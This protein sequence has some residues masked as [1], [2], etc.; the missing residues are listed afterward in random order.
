MKTPPPATSAERALTGLRLHVFVLCAL[1]VATPLT[2]LLRRSPEFLVTHGLTGMGT[3]ALI[4]VLLLGPPVPFW[5]LGGFGRL[6]GAGRPVISGLSIA[7][8]LSLILLQIGVR[9]GLGGWGAASAGLIGGCIGAGAYLRLPVVRTFTSALLLV[10][11]IAPLRLALSPEI[12]RLT[13]SSAAGVALE[14]TGAESSVVF[15]IFDELPMLSLTLQDGN[16]DRRNFPNFAL[17]AATSHVFIDVVSISTSTLTAV[18][19]I[20]RGELPRPGELPN[21]VDAPRNLFTLFGGDHSIRAFEPVT[22]LC[23]EPLNQGS[24]SRKRG[25]LGTLVS[26]LWIVL[27]HLSLPRPWADALPT[28][29]STWFDFAG[30]GVARVAPSAG[31]RHTR[32]RAQLETSASLRGAEFTRFV[33]GL[34]DAEGPALHFIHAALPHSPTLFAPDGRIYSSTANARHGGRKDDIWTLSNEPLVALAYQRHLLQL[35]YVDQLLG[36]L[37]ERLRSLGTFDDTTL[38]VTADHGASFRPGQAR[39]RLTETNRSEAVWVP[40]FIKAAGQHAA[41]VHEAPIQTIDIL[42]TLVELLGMGAVDWSFDGRSALDA[43]EGDREATDASAARAWKTRAFGSPPDFSPPLLLGRHTDLIGQKVL[44]LPVARDSGV[45][46]RRR[47]PDGDLTYDPSTAAVPIWLTGALES[48]PE[49]SGCCHVA[50]AVNGRI[51]AVQKTYPGWQGD[52][53]RFQLLFSENALVPGVNRTGL[54]VVEGEGA[55]RRLL[56]LERRASR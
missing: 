33:D 17:L 40:V 49:M 22:Q 24:P 45:R 5:V 27:Q 56:T 48:S 12:R 7:L 47:Q 44:D 26:D 34:N 20:L 11:L 54:Y 4:L 18:P 41:V 21:L 46:L 10:A 43:A 50:L 53:A 14:S 13:P 51:V 25:E 19:A 1:A 6:L 15:V 37:I 42:P 29:T 28:V 32:I 8:P 9:A 55:S 38:V 52:L 3:I 16:I 31:S 23:P 36:L 35:Q 30:T 2:Q 39:R